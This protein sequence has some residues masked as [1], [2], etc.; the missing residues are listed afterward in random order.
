MKVNSKIILKTTFV[1]LASILFFLIASFFK[2]FY[3]I[4]TYSAG[5]FLFLGD[6]LTYLQDFLA[7]VHTSLFFLIV[8]F[9]ALLSYFYYT[10]ILISQTKIDR[11]AKTKN[12]KYGLAG[13]VFTYLG[14]GCVA[15]G[16]TLLY[17]FLLLLGSNVSLF[18]APVI[19]EISLL[20]GI[21]FL[22]FG[23]FKNKQILKNRNLCKI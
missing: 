4:Y 2:E 18:L 16:Q 1:W 22:L 13:V 10:Y 19:G 9:S 6:M 7:T 11:N 20:L 14:F 21:V 17:S 23:V 15:C 12:S 3:Q 8:I 5:N